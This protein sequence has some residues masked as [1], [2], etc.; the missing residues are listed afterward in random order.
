MVL[1]SGLPIPETTA[2]RNLGSLP[3]LPEQPPRALHFPLRPLLAKPREEAA[4]VA[5][6]MVLA[7]S[8][9]LHQ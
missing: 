4:R 6:S 8:P 7:R 9:H 5:S 3:M 2:P 1:A